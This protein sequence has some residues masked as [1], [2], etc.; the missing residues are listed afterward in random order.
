MSCVA[1]GSLSEA[2][3]IKVNGQNYPQKHEGRTLK[4][5]FQVV[6]NVSNSWGREY[7]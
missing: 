3:R 7:N 6:L 4:V 2:E 5:I 1:L